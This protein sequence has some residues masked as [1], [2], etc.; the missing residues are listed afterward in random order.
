M[1]VKTFRATRMII[2][3]VGC[4][5]IHA[6]S[7]I[8]VRWKKWSW[9]KVTRSLWVATGTAGNHARCHKLWQCTTVYWVRIQTLKD[10]FMYFDIKSLKWNEI[11]KLLKRAWFEK[12]G[13]CDLSHTCTWDRNRMEMQV[14][15][16]VDLGVCSIRASSIWQTSPGLFSGIIFGKPWLLSVNFVCKTTR[17]RVMALVLHS[18]RVPIP[19]ANSLEWCAEMTDKTAGAQT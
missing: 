18:P 6:M 19:L 16:F 12:V 15:V 3:L 14:F 11:T 8:H 10:I 13:R 7:K 5:Y 2:L 17:G 9:Q 1:G 4:L